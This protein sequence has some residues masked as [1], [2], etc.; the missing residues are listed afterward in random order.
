MKLRIRGNSIRLRLGRA[1][2]AELVE[3]GKV[4]EMTE[5]G[6]GQCLQYALITSADVQG[7]RATFRPA[8]IELVVPERLARDWA[9]GDDV[10]ISAEQSLGTRAGEAGT[11]RLLI[12]KDFAC[13]KA[14][15]GED[16]SD[17]FSHPEGAEC[18]A[19]P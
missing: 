6:A 7:P 17:A 5:F 13:L 3:T 9:A 4:E 19:D 16:Q 14:P 15:P 2:V 18:K 8:R 11:L 1:E 12:E 10:G